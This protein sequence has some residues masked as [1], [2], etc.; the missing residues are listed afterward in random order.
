MAAMVRKRLVTSESEKLAWSSAY[1]PPH[2]MSDRHLTPLKR[3]IPGTS[4]STIYRLCFGRDPM[5]THC[6]G[7]RAF[8]NNTPITGSDESPPMRRGTAHRPA[9]NWQT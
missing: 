2:D 4:A 9:A 8:A 7:D 3:S 6:A 1:A 5:L